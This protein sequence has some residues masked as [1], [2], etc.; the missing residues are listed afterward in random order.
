MAMK[1]IFRAINLIAL[2]VSV[3]FVG[4]GPL[5]FADDFQNDD[6]AVELDPIVISPRRLAIEEGRIAENTFVYTRSEIEQTG[7]RDLGEALNYIPGVDVKV[8]NQFGQ[9]T[10]V[11]IH[12]SESRQVL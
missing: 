10:S 3:C 4:P 12:G 1:F 7:A 6:S 11:S 2:G 8:T 9:G 5:T